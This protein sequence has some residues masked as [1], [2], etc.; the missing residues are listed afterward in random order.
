MHKDRGFHQVPA[1][2]PPWLDGPQVRNLAKILQI[3]EEEA[4]QKLREKY[5]GKDD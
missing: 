2:Y 3:T 1:N 4:R 5:G